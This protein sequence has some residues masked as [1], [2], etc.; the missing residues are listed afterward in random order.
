M[1]RAYTEHPFTNGLADGSLAEAAF[2]HL[3]RSGLLVPQPSL[4]A[5]TRSPST[6]RPSSLTCAKRPAGLS[7][8][9]DIEMN[10]HV[11]LCAG[12]GPVAQR[13]LNKTPPAV[14]MLALYT[15]RARRGDAAGDLLA[16]KGGACPPAVIRLTQRSRRGLASATRCARCNEPISR[17]DR[18]SMPVP[19]YQEVAAKARGAPWKISPDLY[20]HAPAPPRGR[21]S[22]RVI[23]KAKPPRARSRLLGNGLA[24]RGA[25]RGWN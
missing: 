11:K 20:V 25:Q 6:S 19:P 9:L 7:P 2:R 13:I 21:S 15:L 4:L 3:P 1:W 23:F 8:I 12:W 10:L 18:R 16:L 14:E 17:L 5:P 22:N 24:W